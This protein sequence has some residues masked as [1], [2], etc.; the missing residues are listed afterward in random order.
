MSA[1]PTGAT[2][3]LIQ[4]EP[5]NH[6][7]YDAGDCLNR[8]VP[9]EAP[10][11]DILL[12]GGVPTPETPYSPHHG[13]ADRVPLSPSPTTLY[14]PIKAAIPP[15]SPVSFREQG[16]P[17]ARRRPPVDIRKRF[18]PVSFFHESAGADG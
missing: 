9:Q 11:G 1:L 7:R 5:Q 10:H 16:K 15:E 17:A 18:T 4:N 6:N 12:S 13:K 2:A 3:L 14:H 8:H